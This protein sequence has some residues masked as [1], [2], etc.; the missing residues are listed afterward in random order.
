MYLPK[1]WTASVL[2]LVYLYFKH[3]S[4]QREE[5]HVFGFAGNWIPV[6]FPRP[7]SFK[8]TAQSYAKHSQRVAFQN[9][10]FIL[11][12][13]EPLLDLIIYFFICILP[14]KIIFKK[15]FA[16]L[17]WLSSIIFNSHIMFIYYYW[18]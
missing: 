1:K 6:L 10:V 9:A 16:L 4:L 8:Y 17:W 2:W 7:K 5:G 14:A 13:S 11:T 15:Y 18:K 3:I 12:I